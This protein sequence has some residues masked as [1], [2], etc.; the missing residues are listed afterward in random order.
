MKRLP[1]M[2]QGKPTGDPYLDLLAAVYRLAMRD[3]ERGNGYAKRWLLD[4]G[5]GEYIRLHRAGGDVLKMR[6]EKAH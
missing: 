2:T 5:A 3:A 1:E 6:R 4:V